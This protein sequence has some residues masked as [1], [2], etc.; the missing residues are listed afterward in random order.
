MIGKKQSTQT[1]YI[2]NTDGKPDDPFE[3]MSKQI[4]CHLRECKK[5]DRQDD[6]YHAQTGHD[7]QCDKHHQQILECCHW[8]TLGACEFAVERNGND[9]AE[10]KSEEE[11]QYDA[12]Y[13][14]QPDVAPGDGKNISKEK[15]RQVRSKAGRQKAEDDSHSHTEGPEHGDSR[16]F[17]HV[18]ALAE[19]FHTECRQNGEDG[20]SEQGREAGVQADTYA[21]EGCM[22]DTAADEDQPSR[23][24]I[25]SDD[26]ACN[27]GKEAAQQGILEKCIL[28]KFVHASSEKQMIRNAGSAVR[29]Q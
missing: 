29:L 27:A 10:E 2:T 9:R 18:A 13:S 3:V 14:Q 26:A 22:C 11:R 15:R 5:G 19:P 23:H 17:A 8:N 24:D 12:Q 16:V 20:S 28:E 1:T 21:S 6:T 25:C 7:G 4:G